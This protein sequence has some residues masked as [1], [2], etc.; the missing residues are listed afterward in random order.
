MY[1]PKKPGALEM[2]IAEV[3]LRILNSINK[4]NKS[5]TFLRYYPPQITFFVKYASYQILNDTI[6][7]GR[8]SR[9]KKYKKNFRARLMLARGEIFMP[10]LA[11]FFAENFSE[12]VIRIDLK[13]SGIV[14][15]NNTQVLCLKYWCLDE[16]LHF[17]WF[18]FIFFPQI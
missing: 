4:Y 3:L 2:L 12:T 8:V 1:P 9:K 16:Y 13:F 10:I 11:H 7:S 15:G 14:D 6:W 17:Y 5:I 18:F